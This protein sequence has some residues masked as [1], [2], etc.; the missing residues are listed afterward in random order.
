M[1]EV[2]FEHVS[3]Q[4]QS[5]GVLRDIDLTIEDGM[6][7]VVLGP[8]GCGKSTLLNLVA[9]LEPVSSG[10]IFI[11]G[12]DVTGLAPQKRNIAMVF[13]SYALYPHLNVFENIA[14]GLRAR[15]EKEAV[16]REKVAS[17]AAI[18]NLGGKLN[19]LPRELSGGERQRVATGRAIVRDPVLFLFDEPLSNLDARLRVELRGEFIKLHKRLG[20]TIMYVTHDQAEAQAMGEKIVVL[21]DGVIQQISAPHVLYDQPAN[22]FVARFI[23]SPPMNVLRMT[24]EGGGAVL[25]KDGIAVPLPAAAGRPDAAQVYLGFRPSGAYLDPSGPLSAQA[26][27]TEVI[28]EDNFCRLRLASGDEITVKVSGQNPPR[29]NERVGVGI[30]PDKLYLFSSE[31]LKNLSLQR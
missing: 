25:A 27:F 24:V 17:A 1:A 4:F 20:K 11:D 22:L 30:H 12:R 16:I 26:E 18:L 19:R 23:G 5:T 3:K 6:F 15:G 7:C 28:G 14:F 8:S 29:G 13:Q 31:T 21:N 2:R 10:R 9:G